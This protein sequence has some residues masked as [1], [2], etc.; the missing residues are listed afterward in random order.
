MISVLRGVPQG[1][2]PSLGTVLASPDPALAEMV[3]EAFDLAWI[4]LEH[5][6]LDVRDVLRLSLALRAGRC[7]ALVRLSGS[8]FE[9]LDAVLDCGV[10]GVVVPRV[11]TAAEAAAVVAQLRHPPHGR[12]GHALRRAAG[13]GRRAHAGVGCLIQIESGPAV[14]AAAAIAAVPGVDGLVVGTADLALALGVD[15]DLHSPAM[16]RALADV[17]DATEAA[18]VA[19]GL[20]T[21]GDPADIL[22]AVGRRP[23]LVVY[24]A[25]VRMY[26]DAI[27]AARR[28]LDDALCV[29]AP[30]AA[31]DARRSPG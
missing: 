24:S 9:R 23:D 8:R 5:G 27:D 10:D 4:D 13:Y 12:R 14:A 20:A 25:D 29:P 16:R 3:A 18:G 6:P 17:R 15:L 28:R 31:A 21:G 22:D 30:I 26:V 11:E 19:F 1:A 2:R 7:A